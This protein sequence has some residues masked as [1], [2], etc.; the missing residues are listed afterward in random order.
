LKRKLSSLKDNRVYRDLW[1]KA[2]AGD[3][4]AFCQ[5]GEDHYAWLFAYAQNYTS[6]R[7]LIKDTIQDLYLHLWE[8]RKTIQIEQ[9]S[10]YLLR[11]M[12]N[13]IL[14]TYRKGSNF[15]DLP[16]PNWLTDATAHTIESE[17][18][19][20][21]ITSRNHYHLEK[22]ILTLPIRQREVIF[23]KYYQ[24]LENDQIAS[25]I[26]INRQSVANHLFKA[27]TKLR[28]TVPHLIHT[29]AWT[30]FCLGWNG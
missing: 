29:G 18:I 1:C 3:K 5:L 8:N 27:L 6:D 12:R 11:S 4:K 9:I 26:N 24:G 25:L 22:A 2:K 16:D 20:S 30:L 10:M 13:N 14:L 19:S 28:Q 15:T 17:I 23:L 21:E 7:E